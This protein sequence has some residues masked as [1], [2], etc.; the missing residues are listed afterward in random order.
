MVYFPQNVDLVD[1]KKS[2]ESELGLIESV[3]KL[4]ATSLPPSLV[5]SLQPDEWIVYSVGQPNILCPVEKGRS[6]WISLRRARQAHPRPQLVNT[7]KH[8]TTPNPRGTPL[9]RLSRSLAFRLDCG[10][11]NV[12]EGDVAP[13]WSQRPFFLHSG[14]ARGL[15]TSAFSRCSPE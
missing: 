2:D 14:K 5:P 13:N 4:S 12:V 10:L 8:G 7:T 9:S 6:T 11:Q 15:N 3:S 1:E